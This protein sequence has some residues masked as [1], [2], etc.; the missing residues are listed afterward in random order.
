MSANQAVYAHLA[1]S[2]DVTL[3][4]PATWRDELRREPYPAQRW[5]DFVG[6]IWAVR[7]LGRGRPQRHLSLLRPGRAL[8]SRNTE[9]LILEEEP[10]SFQSLWWASA[11]RR[12]KVPYAV[13]VAENLPREFPAPVRWWCRRVLSNAAF[14]LAR[15]PQ[16]LLQAQ[17]WG[18][19]GQDAVVPHGVEG[20]VADASTRSWPVGVVGFVG[21]LVEAK[22]VEDVTRLLASDETLT[23]RVAGDGPLKP[24]LA[25][26]GDRVELLG[27]LTP[28]EMAAFYASVSVVVVPSRTTPTWSEQFG[29]VIIE[30]QEAGV[31]V[32]AYDSGEIPWVASL[33]AAVLVPEGDETALGRVTRE[34]AGDEARA[35]A[36]GA[37]GARA[38]R[39]HFTND[40]IATSLQTLIDAATSRMKK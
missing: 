38:V 23:L 1:S 12:A 35:R 36:L 20:S 18:F 29:R 21:R 16:A 26:L 34:V 4:V 27:T 14:V 15:S 37:E 24:R 8:R 22:G 25:A 33:T 19:R 6:E 5:S 32:V 31:P 11:A 9:F 10:F 28:E 3:V 30:A 40:V 2:C 39:A 7:T 17:K 13:Q